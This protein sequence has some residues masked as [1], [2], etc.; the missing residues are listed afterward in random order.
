[1]NAAAYLIRRL[2]G[3]AVVLAA[4][5]FV[6]FAVFFLIPVDPARLAAGKT[7]T[8]TA[9]AQVR[10]ALGLDRPWYDQY[11]L[12]LRKLVL[13]GSLG[14]SYNTRQPVR[15][16]VFAAAPVTISLVAGA[17]LIWLALGVCLGTLAALRPRS[18]ADRAATG[19]AAAAASV[20]PV[21]LSLDA[22]WL[23]GFKLGWTPISGYCSISGGGGYGCG[24]L[25]AW[26]SHLVL[27][28]CVLG[29]LQSALYVRLV[30]AS[31]RETLSADWVRTARA[32]GL[33][34]RQI[35]TRHVL[36]PVLAPLV[37]VAGL[38]L[39]LLLGGVVFVETVFGLPGLGYQAVQS[40]RGFDL[41][42]IE[43]IVIYAT[44]IIV[45]CNLL[46]DLGVQRLDPR[47]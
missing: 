9:I 45:V 44:L 12:Y 34:E 36:L 31:V 37:T 26:A 4:V 8:P 2:G 16:I 19:F 33:P 1:M 7:A 21:W 29:L 40:L 20:H 30:R 46:V 13:H 35:L 43:G 11:G 24:G 28:W 27:P 23:V 6:T 17:F 39:A 41:P 10:A 32:K 25:A 22:A 47:R 14:Y 18:F 5:S 15:E 3:A 42:T 38:D